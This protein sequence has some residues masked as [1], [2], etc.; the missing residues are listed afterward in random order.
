MKDIKEQNALANKYRREANE[1][2]IGSPYRTNEYIDARL[3][4][5]SKAFALAQ[6]S[7][8]K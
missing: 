2:G 7:S 6:A 3:K 5:K 4:G 8:R 1:L